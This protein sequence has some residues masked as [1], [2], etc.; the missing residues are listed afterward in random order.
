MQ[1]ANTG[2]AIRRYLCPRR[3]V[4]SCP[5]VEGRIG[6]TT[7]QNEKS[8]SIPRRL[9]NFKDCNRPSSPPILASTL[10]VQKAFLCGHPAPPGPSVYGGIISL[11]SRIV[12]N[13]RIRTLQLPYPHLP[14]VRRRLTPINQY[15]YDWVSD[16]T[17]PILQR[18]RDGRNS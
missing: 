8:T 3:L 17:K 1:Q 2:M 15:E 11:D 13:L 9:V 10:N 14:Y 6:F 12:Q 16:R 7:K 5:R 4:V 18:R